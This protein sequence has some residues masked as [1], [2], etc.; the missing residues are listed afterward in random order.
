MPPA[1]R[2]ICAAHAIE[3]KAIWNCSRT[4][5]GLT[6]GTRTLCRPSR[7]HLHHHPRQ[8]AARLPEGRSLD[9]EEGDPSEVKEAAKNGQL[10]HQVTAT[11]WEEKRG[12]IL[13]AFYASV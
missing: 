12:Y 5:R 4:R 8:L 10:I 1:V 6:A 3:P 7:F 11:E 9:I 2:R 13:V